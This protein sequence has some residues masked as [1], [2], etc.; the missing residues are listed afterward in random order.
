MAIIYAPLLSRRQ[1]LKLDR[2]DRPVQHLHPDMCVFSIHQCMQESSARTLATLQQLT[3]QGLNGLSTSPVPHPSHPHS[4]SKAQV[5]PPTWN[6]PTTPGPAPN[7]SVAR[8]HHAPPNSVAPT[9]LPIAGHNNNI[10]ALPNQS[11]LPTHATGLSIAVPGTSRRD[12]SSAALRQALSELLSKCSRSSE[13]L[14]RLRAI[15]ASLA[16]CDP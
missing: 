4:P 7:A 8:L 1:N 11:V 2:C 3:R 16:R 9:P 12:T 10:L 13:R 6:Q 14:A 15:L 5:A